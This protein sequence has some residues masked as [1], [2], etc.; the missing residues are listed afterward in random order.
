MCLNKRK[1]FWFFII[2]YLI[3]LLFSRLIN[4]DRT[5]RFLWDE[6]SDLVRMHRIYEEKDLTLIG[7]ISEDGNK[8]FGSLTY[9]MLLPFAIAGNFHPLSTSVGAAFWGIATS[10]IVLILTYRINKSFIFPVAFLTLTWYPLVETGRWAW[11]PNLIP[12]WTA[13][14]LFFYF[15]K[16]KQASF[17]SG[18]FMSLCLHHHYISIFAI[19]AYWLF[20]FFKSIKEKNVNYIISFSTGLVL[21]I[22]PFIIFDLTHPPGLFLSRIL[23]FNYLSTPTLSL[24]QALTKILYV[25]DHSFT[26]FVQVTVFR[27]TLYPIL[28]YLIY[29]DINNRSSA[30]SFLLIFVVQL[31][32]SSIVEVFNNHYILPGMVFFLV[33]LIYPRNKKYSNFSL[34]SLYLIIAS[35]L[36]T[37]FP[38]INKITWQ[39]DIKTTYNISKT[40]EEIIIKDNLKNNNIAVI[41]SPDNNI[42]GRKFRDLLEIRGVT[43]KTKDEYHISDHLFVVSTSSEEVLRK[44]TSYEMSIFEEGELMTYSEYENSDWKLYV[45]K[46]NP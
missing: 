18:L 14:S 45:F 29:K 25:T 24:V 10:I 7:P 46:H 37:F 4:L 5:A 31:I 38:Q 30:L 44:D 21:A 8:V 22:A 12:F 1:Y 39:T 23:Y 13:I 11:N 41:A 16:N 9:Y 27:Y 20:L 40:V 43:F 33:Y 36:I 19:F 34:A 32:G 35:S 3:A 42:Y 2:I 6:S 15:F 28:A 26:Y 17:L